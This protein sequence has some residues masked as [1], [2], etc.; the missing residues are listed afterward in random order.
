MPPGKNS[1]FYKRLQN[2]PTP[3]HVVN[4]GQAGKLLESYYIQHKRPQKTFAPDRFRLEGI[5]RRF[6]REMNGHEGYCIGTGGIEV[7]IMEGK[8]LLYYS[9]KGKNRLKN[10]EIQNILMEIV[11]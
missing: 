1:L 9:V 4:P 10:T 11:K 3:D 5:I 7:T 6:I 2:N 8:A